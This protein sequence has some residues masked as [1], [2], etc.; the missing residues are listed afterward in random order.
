MPG[1]I[2]RKPERVTVWLAVLVSC[3][4]LSG[5]VGAGWLFVLSTSPPG[6]A[7]VADPFAGFPDP[8]AWTG[9]SPDAGSLINFAGTLAFL[10]WLGMP[11]PVLLLGLRRLSR[12]S[13]SAIWW[14]V[15]W[16]CAVGA[17]VVLA[18]LFVTSYHFPPPY[19]SFVP[20]VSWGELAVALGFLLLGA[21]MWLM[22][23][24]LMIKRP[25]STTR[26][27]ESGGKIRRRIGAAPGAGLR[28]SRDGR[29]HLQL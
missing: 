11:I 19:I 25:L 1:T 24:Y 2:A 8:P 15:A 7:G 18:V 12:V 27:P 5:A 21:I 4:L 22:M 20:V 28:V 13:G 6:Q 10:P 17:G 3:W 9:I 26:T 14:K 16:T 23:W 29:R